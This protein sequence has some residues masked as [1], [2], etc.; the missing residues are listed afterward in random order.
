MKLTVLKDK[1]ISYLKK[2]IQYNLCF[3][4]KQYFYLFKK[5]QNT[6]KISSLLF[7]TEFSIVISFNFLLSTSGLHNTSFL[8]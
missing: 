6:Y 3:F 8:I 1:S 2:K 7:L 5:L 4:Q